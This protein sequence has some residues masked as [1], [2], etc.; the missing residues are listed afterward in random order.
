MEANVSLAARLLVLSS[1]TALSSCGGGGGGGSGSTGPSGPPSSTPVALTAANM[2]PV[3]DDVLNMSLSFVSVGASDSSGIG[4]V[5]LLSA[6]K[7]LPRN[8]P[9]ITLLR[10]QL[11]SLDARAPMA[12]APVPLATPVPCDM[13]PDGTT[14]SQTTDSQPTSTTVTF[15]NCF[16]GGETINGTLSL[17]NIMS[18]AA[19]EFTG[20]V[21]HNLTFVQVGLPTFTSSG[22]FDIDHKTVG[23]VIT[24]TLTGGPLTLAIGPDNATISGLTITSA[25]D[26][27]SNGE[28]DTVV[29]TIATNTIGGSVTVTTPT[30]FQT[31]ATS[32]FPHT[33]QFLIK[34]A[35]NSEVRFTVLGDETLPGNQVTLEVDPEGD[36]TF[37]APVGMTW[38]AL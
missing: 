10:R 19:G 36:G 24:D 8:R 37:Q 28:T 21:S 20:Q 32:M 4:D 1:I 7:T 12:S 9:L 30:A 16:S 15:S 11:G 5:P 2:Q 29:A 3:T 25:L 31:V 27:S 17:T 34:G 14:G 6:P 23:T 22:N 38:A 13:G 33:G 26:S 18:P 35:S